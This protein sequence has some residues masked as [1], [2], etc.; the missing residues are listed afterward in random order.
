[1]DLQAL[2]RLLRQKR[3]ERERTLEDA[4][5]TLRI[6]QHILESFELGEF[7]LANFSPVQIN[8]FIRNY[9]RWLG[10][11]EE[12]ILDHY[13]VAKDATLRRPTRRNKDKR[14][15]QELRTTGGVRINDTLPTLPVRPARGGAAPT[16]TR[17]PSPERRRGGG[18]LRGLLVAA[19]AVGALALIA[20]VVVT[21]ITETPIGVF[22]DIQPDGILA[23]MPAIATFTLAP[24]LPP[25]LVAPTSDSAA[26]FSGAG[27]SVQ[28]TLAQRSWLRIEVDGAQRFEGVGRPGTVFEFAASS[29]INVRA[30][31]AAALEIVYNGQRQ[32]AFGTRGQRV[33]LAFS[34]SG[35]QVSSGQSFA[36]PTLAVTETPPP[37]SPVDV[38]TL[39][40]AQT[41]SITPGPSPTAT[42]TPLPSATP[43][44]TLTPSPTFTASATFTPS[45]TPSATSTA[46][47]SPTAT[48]ILPV[49]E[50]LFTPTATK[51][52]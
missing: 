14:S 11:D 38:G 46:G 7:E 17:S 52:G 6:R 32:N 35:V 21:F 42:E 13:A 8:G 44:V 39:I 23:T 31:N 15:T 51:T 1:M 48:A 26:F 41:P 50:P 19:L 2:G 40:A 49:R 29:A 24:T 4:E 20:F 33:D 18:W 47:P 27:V 28:I 3:E 25:S 37:T 10:L 36:E 43:T 16:P 9:A 34:A 22:E 12:Q 45:A 30:A 5:Q